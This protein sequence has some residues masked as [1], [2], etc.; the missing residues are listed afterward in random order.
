MKLPSETTPHSD[1]EHVLTVKKTGSLI[2]EQENKLP[3]NSVNPK[4]RKSK[5]SVCHFRTIQS[6]NHSKNSIYEA[7]YTNAHEFTYFVHF[8]ASPRKHDR[9]S[10]TW[11]NVK[12]QRLPK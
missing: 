1:H 3:K 5:G 4:T 11:N 6:L 8:T 7:L 10:V 12:R 2:K 9:Y